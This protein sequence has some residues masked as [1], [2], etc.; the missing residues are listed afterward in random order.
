[1]TGTDF[2]F[3]P[4]ILTSGTRIRKTSDRFCCRKKEL[5]PPEQ[6]G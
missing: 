2:Q 4:V 1:M 3:V 5:A 6:W